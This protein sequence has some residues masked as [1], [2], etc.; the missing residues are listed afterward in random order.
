MLGTSTWLN[1]LG[2]DREHRESEVVGKVNWVASANALL[3]GDTT[4]ST[5][6]PT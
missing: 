5:S 1:G 3:T 6:G 2:Y 4:N